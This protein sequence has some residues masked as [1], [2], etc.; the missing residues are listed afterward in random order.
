M[1]FLSDANYK[2]IETL[3]EEYLHPYQLSGPE[4]ITKSPKMITNTKS[5]AGKLEP[6]HD[7]QYKSILEKTIL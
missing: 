3:Y 4:V 1:F 2:N 5:A 6:Q 7:S